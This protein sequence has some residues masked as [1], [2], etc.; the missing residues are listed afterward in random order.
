MARGEFNE[1]DASII[2]KQLVEALAYLHKKG[3]VHRDLKPENILFKTPGK[4]DI[5]VTD[6]GFSRLVGTSH[7]LQT[8]C[9]TPNYVAPEILQRAGHGIEVDMWSTGAIAYSLLCGYLPFS[10]DEDGQAGMFEKI[11]TANYTFPVEDWGEISSEAKDFISSM[12]I[13]DPAKRIKS[14]DAVNHPWLVKALEEK[15][16]V[17]LSDTLKRNSTRKNGVATLKRLTLQTRGG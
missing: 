6:F 12:L 5:L 16:V 3:I 4:N 14:K 2:C 15:P 7:F 11:K 8:I 1:R 13:A 17:D 10:A 9:G